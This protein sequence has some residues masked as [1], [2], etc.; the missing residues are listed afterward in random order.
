MFMQNEFAWNRKNLELPVMMSAQITYITI[1]TLLNL[2]LS[3]K[4]NK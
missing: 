3:Q 4:I 1:K 2:E